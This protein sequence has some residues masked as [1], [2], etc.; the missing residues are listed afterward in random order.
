M[1]EIRTAQ[2]VAFYLFDVAE[3][4]HP[5]AVTTILGGTAVRARLAPKPADA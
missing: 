1:A 4:A 5:Q 3:S 2:I